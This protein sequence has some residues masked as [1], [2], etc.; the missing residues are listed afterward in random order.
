M[1][2]TLDGVLREKF[3]FT[4]LDED[5]SSFTE[6][7]TLT[8]VQLAKGLEFDQVVV[9]FVSGSAYRNEFEKGLLYVACTRAMHQLIVMQDADDPSQLIIENQY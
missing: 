7:I 9:P 3:T 6:G 5:S 8:T 2:Q 4:R 1:V